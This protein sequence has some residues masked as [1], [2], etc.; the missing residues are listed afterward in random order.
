[1]RIGA[2]KQTYAADAALFDTPTQR[3][4]VAAMALALVLFP[5]VASEYWLYLACLVA[6]HIIS[7]AGLNI[8]TGYTGLVSLGQAAYSMGIDVPRVFSLA[9]VAAA[10]IAC[11][12]GIVVGSI[13]GIS[14]VM[15]VFGLSV[16]V[17]VIFGGFGLCGIP[18]ALIDALTGFYIG[19]EYRL[20]ATFLLLVLVLLVRPYGLFGTHEI[21]RL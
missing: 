17:V 15:G 16:L 18:E 8:L 2:A 19:G 9:W 1:M 4:W 14:S 13:G 21:E 11:V 20:L 7:A 12:A 10:M 5:F 3:S 6:I